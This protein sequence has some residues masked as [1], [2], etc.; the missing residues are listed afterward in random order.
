MPRYPDSFKI[1]VAEKN[2]IEDVVAEY[3]VL[4][5][6]SGSNRFGLCPFH[7]EKTPSF[8]V[9]PSKQIYYCF[10][11]G[12]GGDV[13]SFIRDVENITY[14][15]AMEFLARRAGIPVPVTEEDEESKKRARIY[16]LNK[17]AARFFYGQLSTPDGA[18]A[19]QY[20]ASRRITPTTVTNFGLGYAPDRWSGLQEAMRAKGFT[21][22]EMVDADLIRPGKNGYYDTFRNRLVFPVI[23]VSGRVIGFS[24]RAI[25]DNTPK[26]LNSRDTPVFSKGHNLFGLNL[27]KKS[28]T[29]YIILVEGNVDVVS[30]HQAGFD[31][32]VASLG[33]SLT[34]E[35]AR[36]LSRYTDQIILAYDSDG[37]GLKA[38]QRGIRILE[39]LNVRVKVLRWDGAK[40]PDE[41]IKL[42]GAGAFQNLIQRSE[43]QTDYLLRNLKDKYDFTEDEQKVLYLRDATSLAA[44]LPSQVERQV[45]GGRIAAVAGVD[46]AVVCSE[47]E[48]QRKRQLRT[49]RAGEERSGTPETL[50]QPP[51]RALRYDNP[52]SAIGEEG[53][54]R[55]LYLEPALAEKAER[56]LR[57]EEFTADSLR[58]FYSVF[59]SRI[60]EHKDITPTLLGEELSGP[61]MSLLV[62]IIDKPEK[63]SSAEETLS[64]YIKAIKDNNHAGTERSDLRALA[65][66]M[67]DKGKGYL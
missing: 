18:A 52:R 41:Y 53:V 23:D 63:L 65:E 25:G 48:L 14:P 26:Y 4:S 20:V 12:K 55:M 40:D 38:S 2:R 22:R 60:K 58:H 36:L 9:S 5:K 66:K 54:I 30:L 47:I 33:T 62:R 11:C 46:Q 21:E 13:I 19:R 16:A 27:A 45:Y 37:A 35:Q 8:S 39:K 59:L 15:E 29:G 57:P 50:A 64:D 34:D 10:G 7:N 51:D 3:V 31:S 43:A 42:K 67:K 56:E 44:G 24:G 61:E 1:E 17:E 28:K 32:A 6:H 49:A